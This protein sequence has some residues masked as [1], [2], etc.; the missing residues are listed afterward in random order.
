MSLAC[1]GSDDL[2]SPSIVRVFEYHL[3]NPGNRRER[4]RKPLGGRSPEH[5]DAVRVRRLVRFECEGAEFT[6]EVSGKEEPTQFR[7]LRVAWRAIQRLERGDICRVPV[8]R[9]TQ[10]ELKGTQQH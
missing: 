1:G 9:E 8:A 3:E 4:I 7:V 10:P 6:R 5:E 2:E